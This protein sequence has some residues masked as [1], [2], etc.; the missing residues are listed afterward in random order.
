MAPQS[1]LKRES[2]C[3]VCLDIW[4]ALTL[5]PDSGSVRHAITEPLMTTLY[6][7]PSVNCQRDIPIRVFSMVLLSLLKG[8]SLCWVLLDI[9]KALTLKPDSGSFMNAIMKPLNKSVLHHPIY[10]PSKGRPHTNSG[11]VRHAI[12]EPFNDGS[13]RHPI[14]QPPKWGPHT[15]IFHGTTKSSEGGVLM[16]DFFGCLE[17]TEFNARFWER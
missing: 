17:S 7:I 9:W 8:E 3:R 5:K 13:P 12:T 11:S 15:S 4:K 2:L 6:A 16:P 1:I 14:C 10:P